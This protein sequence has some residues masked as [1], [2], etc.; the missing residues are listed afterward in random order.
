MLRL[1]LLLWV[2]RWALRELASLAGHLL[3][4]GPAPTDS[5]RQPGR[6]P[7]PFD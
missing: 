6:L 7:G 4:R 3:P 5:S 2:G 1:V